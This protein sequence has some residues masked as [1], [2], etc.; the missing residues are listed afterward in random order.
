MGQNSKIEVK[1]TAAGLARGDE[2]THER[3]RGTV[4]H[5]QP[6][7]LYP[8]NRTQP[9]RSAVRVTFRPAN[10]RRSSRQF[11]LELSAPVTVRRTAAFEVVS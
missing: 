7:V 11:V 3:L 1:T 8:R 6:V 2:M 5:L 4:S 9:S 10:A